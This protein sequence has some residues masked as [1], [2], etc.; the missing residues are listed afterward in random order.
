MNPIILSDFAEI[1][2]AE[3]YRLSCNVESQDIF[4]PEIWIKVRSSRDVSSLQI[5]ANWA[6][7]ALLYPAMRLG[8]DIEIHG[9]KVDGLLLMNL[10][11]DIQKLLLA[12]DPST[13]PIN[14]TKKEQKQQ[15]HLPMQPRNDCCY[16][17]ATGF[18]AGVDSLATLTQFG[19]DADNTP[20]PITDIV[21]FPVGRLTQLY[22]TPAR[23]LLQAQESRCQDFAQRKGLHWHILS[24]NISLAFSAG[25][26]PISYQG[27]HSIRNMSHA[28]AL[29]GVIDGF[30]YSSTVAFA[31]TLKSD[32]NAIAYI[33]PLLLNLGST[34]VTRLMSGLGGF[35]RLEKTNLV[36][37]SQ[38]A[39]GM[40]DVCVGDLSLRLDQKIRNCS[41][42]WKCHRTMI[43][44][45]LLGK[46]QKFTQVFDWSNFDKVRPDIISNIARQA[47]R[48][49]DI[50]KEIINALISSG[51]KIRYP[52]LKAFRSR[53]GKLRRKSGL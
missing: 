31:S 46:R 32:S 16:R 47:S 5:G 4:P 40:L 34:N 14:L 44:I 27:S 37:N 28:L 2:E 23:R 18:S 6:V 11:L 1:K 39:H 41:S 26:S 24:S 38:D 50:D 48:G 49:S 21:H 45:E 20:S 25:P 51:E 52:Y 53:I 43:S 42:C 10:N 13:K 9:G 29:N 12:F 35:S 15:T 17:L 36:S 7:M 33:D 3:G 8:L 22:D 30:L 19:T